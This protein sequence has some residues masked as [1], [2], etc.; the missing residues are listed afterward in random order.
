[1]SLIPKKISWKVFLLW[2]GA[3]VFGVAVV[4][5]AGYWVGLIATRDLSIVGQERLSLYQGTLR[6]ALEKH[7]YLP[8]VLSRDEG[9]KKLL[10]EN[11]GRGGVAI[12]VNR[13]L[14]ATNQKAESDVLYVLNSKGTTLAASNWLEDRSFVGHNYAFRPYYKDAIEGRESGFFA[15]GATTGVPG[16]FMSHAVHDKTGVRGVIVAKVDMRPLQRQWHDG[17]EHVFVTDEN[18]VVFLSSRDDWRYRTI[19]PVD[20]VALANIRG[21]RQFGGAELLPLNLRLHKV[22]NGDVFEVG[23]QKYLALKRNTGKPGW[24]MHF[25]TPLNLV[26]EKQRTAWIIGAVLLTLVFMGSLFL[27]ERREKLRSAQ[28]ARQADRFQIINKK[29]QLEI[30]ERK[31]T[32]TQLLKTQEDLVQTGKLAALGQMSTAI[33]HEINQPMAAIRTFAASARLLLAKGKKESVKESLVEISSLTE[34]MSNITGELKSFAQ[35]APVEYHEVDLREAL[36]NAI[37]LMETVW[38]PGEIK[39]HYQDLGASV[40]VKGDLVRLEQVFVNLLRNA[41]DAMEGQRE[42]KIS[43]YL[44]HIDQLAIVIVEDNGTGID[45]KNKDQIFDPFFT[46]KE[47]GKGVGLGLSISYGIIQDFGGSI[48]VENTEKAGARF[49]VEFE[50]VVPSSALA[51]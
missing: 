7:R 22:F 28:R 50:A 6:S 31:R 41:A 27:R 38:K 46:T 51:L 16:Y 13:S 19:S 44:R 23:G 34:R 49:I 30:D 42:K 40:F 37:N 20:D 4:Y 12:A 18:G 14:R 25:L 35:K 36:N 5:G 2:L 11:D 3:L 29:L 32:E 45:P 47:V 9:I 39:L 8:F 26:E 24:V 17:G 21:N 10:S 48:R 33:A 15:V 43:V 1:M